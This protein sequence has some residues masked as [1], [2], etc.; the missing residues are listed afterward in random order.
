[1]KLARTNV[2]RWLSILNQTTSL[3]KVKVRTRRETAREN[4][5]GG[6]PEH[7]TIDLYARRN[8]A[9]VRSFS[10]QPIISHQKLGRG[11]WWHWPISYLPCSMNDVM[12][13]LMEFP[14][15]KHLN[16]TREIRS[17]TV[18]YFLGKLTIVIKSLRTLEFYK[19][20]CIRYKYIL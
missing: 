18:T 1:M 17:E 7:V 13:V 19:Y 4:D 3:G 9:Q 20:I 16:I 6:E 12:D 2:D 14:T 11:A 8:K 10:A 5:F 15:G